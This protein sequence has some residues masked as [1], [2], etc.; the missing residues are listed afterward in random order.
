MFSRIA[1]AVVC[2]LAACA[3]AAAAEPSAHVW[4]TTPDGA[5]KLSDQGTVAFHPG[6]S[7][8]LTVTVDPSRGYQRMDGFGAAITDSAA[9][10]L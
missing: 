3:P 10:V 1:V 9:A 7:N 5:L 2:A 6:G 4:V 8:L